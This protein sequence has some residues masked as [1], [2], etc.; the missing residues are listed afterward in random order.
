[1]EREGSADVVKMFDFISII[2]FLAA[3]VKAALS[4]SSI[5][6]DL[7]IIIHNDLLGSYFP[8][9]PYEND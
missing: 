5:D 2:L 6:S 7:S 9:L 4:P 1:M 8:L 3:T